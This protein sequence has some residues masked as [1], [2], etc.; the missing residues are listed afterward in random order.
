MVEMFAM[1]IT[2]PQHY[3]NDSMLSYLPDMANISTSLTF[4]NTRHNYMIRIKTKS[5]HTE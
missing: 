3:V 2:R 5:R 4:F 1:S